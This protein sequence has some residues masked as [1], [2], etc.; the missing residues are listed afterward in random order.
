MRYLPRVAATVHAVLD[1]GFLFIAFIIHMFVASVNY[2]VPVE[3][4]MTSGHLL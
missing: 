4:P 3:Y 1:L 2:T